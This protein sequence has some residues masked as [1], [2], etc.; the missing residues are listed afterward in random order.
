MTVVR[1]T[2]DAVD[3]EPREVLRELAAQELAR[4]VARK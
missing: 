2:E 1:F 4:R 3:R